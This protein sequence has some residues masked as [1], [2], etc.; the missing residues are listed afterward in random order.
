[1]NN[2]V[3]IAVDILLALLTGGFLL[4]FIE[5]MHIESDVK[6]R[7]KSIMNPFYHRLSKMLVFVG[8]MRYS[9]RIPNNRL[10][11]DLKRDIDFISKAAL[12]PMTSGRDVPFMNSTELEKLCETFNR[13]WYQLDR[14]TELRRSIVTESG[15]GLDTAADALCEVYS[16]YRDKSI[17]ID[18][19]LDATGKFYID[20]WQPVEHCTPNYEYW[21]TRAKITRALL[22]SALGM[23]M[24]S[25]IVIMLWADCIC[26][27]I[28]CI[29]AIISS[30]VF[31][32]CV[33]MM[34]HLISLSNRLFRGV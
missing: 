6:Q 13:I 17:D 24:L 28:P 18:D 10:G 3:Q 34:A 1:M 12:V 9:I 14:Y 16:K 15:G 5:T 25:L 20:Y 7:F 23:S 27:E 33:G 22:F 26:V 4:F 19:L 11:E 29:F 31:S 21:E 32:A 8:N 30:V 2:S